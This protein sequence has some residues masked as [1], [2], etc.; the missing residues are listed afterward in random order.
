M[1]KGKQ[2]VSDVA[3]IFGEIT[4]FGAL[5]WHEL[6]TYRQSHQD[7]TF[8][9]VGGRGR[10]V[11]CGRAAISRLEKLAERT[12]SVRSS[13]DRALD[14][15]AYMDALG[16]E[17]VEEYVVRKQPVN[18]RSVART[19][20]RA[21]R[22]ATAA[23]VHGS[24]HI[25][26]EIFSEK[27]PDRFVF[28]PI[29]FIRTTAFLAERDAQIRAYRSD[30]QRAFADGLRLRSPQ[31]SDDDVL[32]E[33][34]AFAT[35]HI[36]RIT[37]H[38]SDH[39]WVASVLIPPS[40][41]DV[42]KAR[43]ER[44]IDAALDALRLFALY[45]PERLR[46]AS[47]SRE[48]RETHHLYS[49]QDGT[50]HAGAFYAGKGAVAGD[51]WYAHHTTAAQH[52]WQPLQE[53]ILPLCADEPMDELN[54]RLLDALDWFGQAIQETEAAPAVVKYTAALERLT[55]TGFVEKG[56]EKLVIK[57][58]LLLNQDRTDK[59]AEQIERD[60]GEL[61]ACRSKLMH[62]SLSPADRRVQKVLRIA[63]EVTRWSIFTA[64][65]LFALIRRHGT[66][67]R[68]GLAAAYEGGRRSDGSANGT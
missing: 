18:E 16:S 53:A 56:I 63:W 2:N 10:T 62:G 43:A 11:F 68:K 36:D 15:H 17:L 50:L 52:L 37:G 58:V 28:G 57:R 45:A 33:A 31:L 5:P 60:L 1:N 24:Y 61:Y 32:R 55:M 64:V 46:R 21:K 66:P 35:R 39:D 59:P 25:P 49:D 42:S 38:F 19:I 27:D 20:S 34:E 29:Q 14:T 51:G 44:A 54:R 4:R 23:L 30:S 65:Q 9:T 26:C 41:P 8:A 12:L 6:V 3:F 13:G 47:S 40:H 22:D 48:P 7:E 67:N